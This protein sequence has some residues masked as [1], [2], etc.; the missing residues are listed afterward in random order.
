MAGTFSMTVDASGAA[1]SYT[2][3]TICRRITAYEEIQA[4]TSD[5]KVYVPPTSS[6]PVTKPAGSKFTHE[7]RDGEG[8]FLPGMTPFAL[9]LVT[10]SATFNF[11][12]E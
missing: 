12:E 4:G 11:E 5:Y 3:Q 7:R 6:T 8:Y 10:G 2:V 9:A 1:E